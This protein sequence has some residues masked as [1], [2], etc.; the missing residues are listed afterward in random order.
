[1]L[2]SMTGAL[3]GPASAMQESSRP[4]QM[5]ALC[6]KN[7]LQAVVICCRQASGRGGVK[8]GS[9][10]IGRERWGSVQG[11]LQRIL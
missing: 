4:L 6:H 1:M 11:S 8:D 7:M 9:V 5:P 3:T 10:H 2:V